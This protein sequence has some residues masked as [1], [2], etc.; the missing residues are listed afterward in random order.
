MNARKT[1]KSHE[2]QPMIIPIRV[3]QKRSSMAGIIAIAKPK[4]NRP[5]AFHF[6]F[7]IEYASATNHNTVQRSCWIP[8]LKGKSSIVFRLFGGIYHRSRYIHFTPNNPL[9]IWLWSETVKPSR[10]LLCI[11]LSNPILFLVFIGLCFTKFIGKY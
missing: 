7:H 2:M 11:S 5:K 1:A 3:S 9:T 10:S 8:I 4:Q 6:R